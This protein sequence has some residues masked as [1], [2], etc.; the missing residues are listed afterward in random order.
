MR[1]QRH[2]PRRAL[3]VEKLEE[4]QVMATFGVPWPDPRSLSVSFPSDDA[5]IGAFPNTVRQ[6]F[7]QVTDRLQWQSEVLR[8]FQTW[9]SVTNVNVG[10]VPDRGDDFGAV[11]LSSNDPRFG[12]IRV[13]AFPQGA[14]LANA[15]PFGTQSGTWSGD[16]LL[17]TE[18]NYYLADWNATSPTPAPSP[19]E[20]GAP[21]ELFSVLLHEAGNALG[22]ADTRTPG[23]VMN[24]TYSGPRGQLSSLDIAAIRRLYGGARRDP[25]ETTTN[26][27][28]STSTVINAPVSPD[29]PVSV[30]GSLNTRSDLDVYRFQPLR[31]QEKVS[32][33]LWAS[34]I[35]LLKARLEVID[36]FGKVLASAQADSIFDNNLQLDIGSLADHPLLYVRVSRNTNDVFAI[37]DYRLDI[38]YRD[39]SQQPSLVPPV[40]DADAND[41]DDATVDFVSV[42]Q[43]FAN[44]LL[45]PEVGNNDLLSNATRLST[46]AGYL[47]RSRYEVTSSISSSADRDLWRFQTPEF[48]SPTMTISIDTLGLQNP[49][50]EAY[51]LNSIGDRV[52]ASTTRKAD[53]GMTLVVNNPGALRNYIVFIRA[54]AGSSVSSGN[55]AVTVDFATDPANQLTTLYSAQVSSSREHISRLDVNKTQLMRFD[56]S[57]LGTNANV[58]TQITIYNAVTGDIELTLASQAAATSTQYVWLGKGSY[59][60]R[61]TLRTRSGLPTT[62]LTTFRVM[63]DVLSDDQGPRPSD[64][65]Q[66]PDPNSNPEFQWQTVD[67]PTVPPVIDY[68]EPPIESPWTSD[69]FQ[70]FLRDFYNL[71]I[72]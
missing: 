38:D 12:E 3:R 48:A 25:F 35:S 33:R 27:S 13:G 1:T 31:D 71:L 29:Q 4:R 2:A 15:A 46:P 55:Y 61:A 8:A 45:D 22:L 64:P 43:L 16:V 70:R 21:V 42:D 32:V 59:F 11:G 41:D 39:L 67:L 57:T 5:S 18:V 56:L 30:S 28:L 68:L 26:N 7:D 69:S 14:T 58:G 53:G 51:I 47:P 66:L 40:H 62:G 24:G 54:L 65:T 49:V 10:L 6:R 20:L 72:V 44:G 9:A 37:G 34:G 17:N 23:T 52:A 36:R 63:V 60:L 50:V 19:N